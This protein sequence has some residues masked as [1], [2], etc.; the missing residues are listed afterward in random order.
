MKN[1]LTYWVTLM[2]MRGVTTRRKNEIY[3]K[4]FIHS[5]QISISELFDNPDVWQEVGMS[6]EEQLLFAEAQNELSNNAFLVE[7]MLSQ[8][9]FII[10]VDSPEYPKTLKKNLK[11]G[12]PTV[13]FAKGNISLLNESSVAIV[14]SRNAD[15]ASLLF[16]DKIVEKSV[17]D[18]LTIVSG[19]AK[20]IDR[21][22]LD[23]S[24]KNMG[25]SIIVLPQGILTFSTGFRQYY[26]D[27]AQGNVLVISTF[28]PKAGWSTGLAMARNSIIY[29]LAEKIYVAQSDSKGGTWNGVTEGLRAGREI[30]VRQPQ[31]EEKNANDL[32]I[33]KGAIPVDNNGN[34][35]Q[36]IETDIFNMVSEPTAK[37]NKSKKA[38][39]SESPTL[40]LD[41]DSLT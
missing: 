9:Y 41:F 12:S 14:G 39:S 2:L 6:D 15:E 21:E 26:R 18:G 5:P 35:L 8:G 28:A 16:A 1:N 29:G 33:E 22:A 3:S 37:Y 40:P 32:L 24:I 10:P 17:Q 27:I 4:C 23:S 13:I 38:S 34:I 11:M 7:D 20:G 19:F 36:R 25:K 30:Y 31:P